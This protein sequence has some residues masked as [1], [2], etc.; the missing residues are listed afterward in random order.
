MSDGLDPSDLDRP[1]W[2]DLESNYQK[3]DIGQ[4]YFVGRMEDHDLDVEHWGIDQRENDDELIYDDT[5][6]LRLWEPQHQFE[7]AESWPTTDSD[8]PLMADGGAVHTHREAHIHEWELRGICDVKTKSSKDWMGIFNLRHLAKYTYWA[9]VYDVPT[10]L[11]FTTVDMEN[12]TI[13]EQSF[14][15]PIETWDYYDEYLKHYDRETDYFIDTTEIVDD[16]HYVERT[17]G[18]N[19]NNAVVVI[20]EDHRYDLDWIDENVCS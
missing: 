20:D 1:D 3:H 19:D 9:D 6:D 4:A 17:F 16:C 15:T 14:V 12:E 2:N 10:F 7:T 11:F 18:A 13:G 8:D 5:M